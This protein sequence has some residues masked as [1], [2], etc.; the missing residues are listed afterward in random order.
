MNT[1]SITTEDEIMNFVA[2][3]NYMAITELPSVGD[4]WAM[5]TSVCQ[6][7]NIFYTFIFLRN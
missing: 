1:T 4:Y 2:I 7:E 6:V 3:L 5:E